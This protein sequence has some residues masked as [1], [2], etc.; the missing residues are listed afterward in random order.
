M[1][2]C[3]ERRATTT[4]TSSSCDFTSSS[5]VSH[6]D[7]FVFQFINH[8]ISSSVV[9]IFT[10]ARVH[11][12]PQLHSSSSYF[13]D[14][15]VKR[16]SSLYVYV[17]SECNLPISDPSTSYFSYDYTYG[18]NVYETLLYFNG[19][20]SSLTIPWL[21][22]SYTES[23]DGKTL[24]FTLRSG[25]TFADGEQLNS[26]SVYFTFNRFLIDDA[27]YYNGHQGGAW[28]LQQLLNTSLSW[29]LSGPHAYTPAWAQQV[30]N[31]NFIQITGPMTFTMHIMH[32]NAALIQILSDNHFGRY[33]CSRLCHAKRPC[34]LEPIKQWIHFA[35][36]NSE[37]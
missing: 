31:E 33:N 19:T 26:T 3:Q 36:C 6:F 24:N 34:T 29:I 15:F 5:S 37:W 4:S 25:I 23:A 17:R 22:Q 13:N 2:H 10:S 28:I 12:V 30:L 11:L 8:L 16:S 14:I 20:S 7:H 35:V 32:P 18:Q 21:A 9:N 1:L 27:A